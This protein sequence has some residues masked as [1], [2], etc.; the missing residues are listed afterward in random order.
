MN[1]KPNPK[2]S[3]RNQHG[4]MGNIEEKIKHMA[5]GMGRSRVHLEIQVSGRKSGEHEKV[6]EDMMALNFPKLLKELKA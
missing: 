5:V 1:W 3:F 6:I 4:K 2:K